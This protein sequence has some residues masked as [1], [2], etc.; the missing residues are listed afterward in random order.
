MGGNSVILPL[1]FRANYKLIDNLHGVRICILFKRRKSF[2]PV[3]NQISNEDQTELDSV[4]PERAP[5]VT[6]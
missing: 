1:H 2:R 6:I 3:S 5:V 4:L